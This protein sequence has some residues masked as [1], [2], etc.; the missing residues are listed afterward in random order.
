MQISRK[1]PVLLTGLGRLSIFLRMSD[2]AQHKLVEAITFVVRPIVS[3]LLQSGIGY[4]QFAELCKKEFVMVA[5]KGYGV[6]GRPTNDSRIAA[7]TGIGRKEVKQIREKKSAISDENN[8]KGV[9]NAPS[10]V[11]HYWHSDAEF[12]DADGHPRELKPSGIKVSF[13]TLCKRYAGDLPPGAIRAELKRAGAI[14][15][16]VDGMLYPLKRYYTPSQFDDAF[17]RSMGFSLSSLASTLLHNAQFSRDGDEKRLL[18]EGHLERYVWSSS[19]SNEDA[20][21]FKVLAEEKSAKLLQELDI[22]IGQRERRS[23]RDA[24]EK[25]VVGLGLY[26]FSGDKEP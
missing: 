15:E 10:L 1:L 22:W 2:R 12:L 24:T 23:V 4:R 11:L 8:E 20:I 6:R 5:R 3:F 19:L 17:I 7:M 26:Y 14:E 16:R 13:E 18:E 9:S 21:D 25:R